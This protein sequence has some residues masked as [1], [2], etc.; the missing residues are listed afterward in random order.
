MQAVVQEADLRLAEIKKATY[1]FDRDV[2]RGSVNPVST[3]ANLYI[4]II[5]KTTIIMLC[6][7]YLSQRTQRI[8][9][10]KVAKYFEDRLKSRVSQTYMYNICPPCHDMPVENCLCT[11]RH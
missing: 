3:H 10:E 2:L 7:V 5:P 9:G 11:D 4:C 6:C 1:E 8:M